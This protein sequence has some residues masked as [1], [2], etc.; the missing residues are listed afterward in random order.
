MDLRHVGGDFVLTTNLV[1]HHGIT[2]IF[3]QTTQL[4]RILDVVEKSLNLPLLCQRLE[5]S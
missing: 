4:I 3:N 2:N 1:V 5:F